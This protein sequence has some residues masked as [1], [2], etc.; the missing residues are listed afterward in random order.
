M[1]AAARRLVFLIFLGGKKFFLL[2][3]KSDFARI[4]Q[5]FLLEKNKYRIFLQKKF[6]DMAHIGQYVN[7]RHP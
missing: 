6:N 5:D 7:F 1:A 4:W 3:E 2:V